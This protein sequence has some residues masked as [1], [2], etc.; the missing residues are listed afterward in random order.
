L[1]AIKRYEEK[2]NCTTI[3]MSTPNILDGW[4]LI[5]SII[6]CILDYITL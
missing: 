2:S 3:S 6:K 5:Q 4:M 1:Q